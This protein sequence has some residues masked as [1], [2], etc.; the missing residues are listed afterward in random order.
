LKGSR[1]AAFL[2]DPLETFIRRVQTHAKPVG[3][4][5]VRI[6]AHGFEP[7]VFMYGGFMSPL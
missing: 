5:G 4:A 1:K 7:W 2:F 6:V 3:V